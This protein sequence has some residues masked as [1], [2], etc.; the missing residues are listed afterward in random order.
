MIKAY[1]PKRISEF[2]GRQNELKQLR[3]FVLNYKGGALLLHG[4]TGCGKTAAV[5]ALANEIDYEIIELNASDIRDKESLLTI[6]G[7]AS[8][9]QSLFKRGKIILI[10]EV[11]GLSA[12]D[13]GATSA[14]SDIIEHSGWP[15]ILTA[16]DVTH[17]KMKELRK[18]CNSVE[19]CALHHSFVFNILRDV[20][21]KEHIAYEE[22]AL[23]SL[24]RQSGGDMRAAFIDLQILA[25]LDDC[26]KDTN[27]LVPRLQR[28]KIQNALMLIFKSKKAENV[29]G[30]FENTDI[31]I[32]ECMLWVDENLPREYKEKDLKTAYDV[33]SRADVFRGRIRRQ[34]HW[35]FLVYMTALLTAGIALAKEKKSDRVVDYK[36]SNRQLKLWLAKIKQAKKQA[37]VEKVAA[38]CHMSR[39][40]AFKE[41]LPFIAILSKQK[42]IIAELGL[43]EEEAK[44]LMEEK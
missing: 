4:P 8:K 22:A 9:Q 15:V 13:R 18:R 33:L 27:I 2:F 6:A 36:R 44:Y 25:L 10:D 12:D 39:R 28:D 23:R 43:N 41:M 30:A 29:L 26:I 31:D 38:Y 3:D 16:N 24:S 40:K 7:N 35:R 21:E 37:I 34:Q 11:D 42:D 20:C 5:Y 1:S 14:I 19:L 32:D 17:E